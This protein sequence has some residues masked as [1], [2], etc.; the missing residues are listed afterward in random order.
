MQRVGVS[1]RYSVLNGV[2][3]RLH[4]TLCPSSL[5]TVTTG[6]LNPHDSFLTVLDVECVDAKVS[7]ERICI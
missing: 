2:T 5:Q 6:G 1:R 4:T 7:W 3:G